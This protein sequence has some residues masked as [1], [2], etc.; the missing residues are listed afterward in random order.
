MNQRRI[1]IVAK[2]RKEPDYRKLS[3][4]LIELATAQ[5]EADAQAAH[6]AKPKEEGSK[7]PRAGRRHADAG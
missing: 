7:R 5:A 6:G 3:R 1:R 4:A 2:R